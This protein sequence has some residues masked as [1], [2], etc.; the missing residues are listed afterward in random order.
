MKRTRAA[1]AA[2]SAGVLAVLAVTSGASTATSPEG[3]GT[4]PV[5]FGLTAAQQ[6]VA[7]PV[8]DP[9]TLRRVGHIRGF[10]GD[11]RLVG[12]DFRVQDG[13][14]Y[15]VGDEGGVYVIARRDASAEKVSQLTVPLVG[16]RFGVDFNPAADRL[17]VVSNAGQNLRHDVNEG[18]TTTVDTSL[19]YPPALTSAQG[20]VGAAYTNNDLDE[21]TSTSLFDVD[22]AL[23]QV[24]IQAPA[25]NGLLSPTGLTGVDASNAGLD[26]HSTVS[27]GK[28]TRNQVY[29]TLRVDGAWGFYRVSPLTGDVEL[30]GRYA[31]STRV[32]DIAV[33]LDRS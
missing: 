28:T 1:L 24:A 31:R 21:S 32:T 15:G 8:D 29:A 5:A 26:V 7:F 17:R 2:T 25:N 20:V 3:K 22:V 10:E 12:I 18:G 14:L 16:T 9:R 4:T 27:E 23:D 19:T 13:R 11:S 33:R 6:L 30:E